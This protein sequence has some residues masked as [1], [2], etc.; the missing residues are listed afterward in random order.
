MSCTRP[1]KGHRGA[2][3]TLKPSLAL[4]I[5]AEPLTVS[6]GKCVSCLIER[7]HDWQ[8]VLYAENMMHSRSCF[9]TLTFDDIHMPFD[10]SIDVAYVQKFIKRVRKRY[11]VRY[12]H[13]A[14]YGEITHRPHHHLILYGVDF[15]DDRRLYKKY[16][17]WPSVYFPHG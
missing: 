13:V 4:Q 11:K 17:V 1:I 2:D 8:K 9:L 6:C 10:F 16:S 3:G 5:D 14:E 15:M 7:R 12:Y